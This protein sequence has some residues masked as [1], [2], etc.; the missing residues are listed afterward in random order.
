MAVLDSLVQDLR[1]AFRVLTKAP[2]ATVLSVVSIALGI[3]L[4]AGVFSLAD[5]W[6]FRPLA[7]REPAG[8]FAL[9]SLGDVGRPIMYG[10]PDFLDASRALSG[11]A[12]FVAY[13]RRGLIRAAGDETETV[14]ASP[15]SP[16][17]FSML[18]VRA[19]LGR[20]SVGEEAGRPEAVIGHRLWQRRFGGDPAI[21]GKTVVFSGKAFVI[22]GVMPEQFTGLERGILTDVWVGTDA[23]FDVLGRRGDRDS[24]RGQFEIAARLKPGVTPERV[25]AQ[26]DAAIRG[27]EKHKPAPPSAPGTWLRS[28]APKWTASLLLGGGLLLALVL[29]LFVACANVAQLR[30]A[31]VESRQRELG[32]R[33]AIGGGGWQVARQLLVETGVVA[34]AGGALGVVLADWLLDSATKLLA[35]V[36]PYID[37]GLRIDSRVLGYTLLAVT[38]SVLF[39]GLAPV[40]HVFRLN[41][42]SILAAG[43]RGGTG[44]GG[45][46]HK[47]L[48]GGQVAVSV[49]LFGMAAMCLASLRNAAA[50]H[51]GIDP[52]KQLFVMTIGR[53]LR[54]EAA[55]WCAQASDRLAGMAGVR[56]VTFA[57]R[58]PLSGS[59]GGMTARVELPGRA[60]LGVRLNNVG[61]NYFALL[62]T[63]VL[64]GR[65]IQPSDTGGSSPV[66]VVSQSFAH[67]VYAESNPIGEWARIDGRERQ[68]V[69]IA[70]DGPSNHIHED[71]EPF[72]WLPYA[73]SPSDDITLMVETVEDPALMARALRAELRRFDPG[74]SIYT[75]QTLRRQM[76]EALA[77]DRMMAS[78]AGG[79]G[80]FGMLLTA[81]GLFGVLQYAVTRRTRELGLRMALGAQRSE[82]QRL[83]LGESLRIAAFAVP[84]GFVLLAAG[85]LGVRSWLLGVGPFD[86]RIFVGSAVGVL[87]LTLVASWL[88]SL[89]ATRV[90]PAVALI[91]E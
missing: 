60:P 53:G 12:E 11:E 32:I 67:Q 31:Q 91:A 2:G 56:G 42:S 18:G 45:W 76:D 90:D 48:I 33:L 10:W 23:W 3:G 19:G 25:A 39:S 57:R 64:A 38:L 65:A 49:A 75:S 83:I 59:G 82:I 35:A 5:A 58:L 52:N 81:A 50:V 87:G 88:P 28:Y 17:Y 66:V 44:G 68:I 73:Q 62:G 16:T 34:I 43:T 69:G 46:R 30:L 61:G 79:L 20:A 78:V 13:Q 74:V 41:V 40:R 71:P 36:V 14:L 72:L 37:Y 27:A 85:G 55:T 70:E 1:V 54:M 26:F 89:R 22:A 63:R 24:R 80:F 84:V 47:V 9:N 6:F 21:V 4:T 29:V 15:V 8:L 51:P 7:V 86:P 77:T